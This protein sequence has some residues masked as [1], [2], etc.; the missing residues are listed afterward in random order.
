[1]AACGPRR[2]PWRDFL[3]VHCANSLWTRRGHTSSAALPLVPH[4]FDTAMW[5]AHGWAQAWL[6]LWRRCSHFLAPWADFLSQLSPPH[7][8]GFRAA[9]PP[10]ST[11]PGMPVFAGFSIIHFPAGLFY[12]FLWDILFA[13]WADCTPTCMRWMAPPIGLSCTIIV[14]CEFQ[15]VSATSCLDCVWPA[16]MGNPQAPSASGFFCLYRSPCNAACPGE[17][18]TIAPMLDSHS[19]PSFLLVHSLGIRLSA[20]VSAWAQTVCCR[21]YYRPFTAIASLAHP[22]VAACANSQFSVPS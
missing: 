2:Q 20:R 22:A 10:A 16:F 18:I 14:C 12:Y 5:S 4:G 13:L 11:V 9:M 6:P 21:S 15:L 3:R 7:G 17:G 8:I 19:F 1:M